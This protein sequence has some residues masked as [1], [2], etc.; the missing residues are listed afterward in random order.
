MHSRR[1]VFVF[2]LLGAAVVS[3]LSARAATNF[4]VT[5][6]GAS[7]Y[8]VDGENNATLN[9]VRGQTYTFT[10]NAT[11]HPFWITTAR[12]AASASTNAVA[13][14][15]PPNGVASGTISW[16]VPTSAVAAPNP[17]FYQCGVHDVMG[18]TLNISDPPPVPAAGTLP[19]IGLGALLAIAS[20]VIIRRRGRLT[21]S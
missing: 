13:S 11:G 15:T 4:N 17:L 20:V 14:V 8:V 1:F 9:L 7:A 2:A 10:I 21:R 16:T 12:G 19:I 6:S 18:G 3:Q 5:N